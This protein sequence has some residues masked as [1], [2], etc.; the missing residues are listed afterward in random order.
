MIAGAIAIVVPWALGFLILAVLRRDESSDGNIERFCFAYPLGIG[1]VTLQMF[2]LG[3]MR[4]S[5]TLRPVAILILFEIVTLLFWIRAGRRRLIWS[6]APGLLREF[7]SPGVSR[8]RKAGMIIL[9]VWVVVKIASILVE[10]YVRPIFAWDSFV[11]WAASAKLF[12]HEG[13]LMLDGPVEEF[14]GQ[15]IMDRHSNY[16]PHIPLMQVWFA[17]WI[18]SFDEVLVKFWC[19]VY[20]ICAAAYLYVIAAREVGRPVSLLIIVLFLSSPLMS[21]HGIEVYGDVVLGAYLLFILGAFLDAVRGKR[22][23][24]VVVGLF[25]ALA[26]F[27]KDE[28]TFFV[29]PLALSIAF[30]FRREHSRG[31]AVLRPLFHVVAPLLIVAPWFVFKFA[32]GRGFGAD[33]IQPGWDF[34]PDMVL[35]VMSEFRSLSNFGVVF[36]LFPFLLVLNGRATR[37]FLHML[38]PVAC[39]GCF[40]VALFVFTKFFSTEISIGTAFYRNLLTY[41]PAAWLLT[42]LLVKEP[43]NQRIHVRA[44]DPGTGIG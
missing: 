2:L 20:L 27:T 42:V 19:P 22:S 6:P 16:P 30:F 29:L 43:L 23:S 9:L 18:G 8:A 24:W 21:L 17:L 33:H 26:V 1:I 13:G 5:L 32:S 15:G 7:C 28:G 31:A 36:V 10:A 41:Y 34:R 3:L 44:S 14:F 40:F 25:S 12:Y 38:F 11:N 35:R 4:V 37:E 39:Y